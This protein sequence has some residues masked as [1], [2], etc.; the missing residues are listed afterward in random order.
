MPELSHDAQAIVDAVL[1]LTRVTM[2]TSG[3]FK[4]KT[5][6]MRILG[7][8]EIPPVRIAAIL[9]TPP[10]NVRSALAKARK[11]AMKSSQVADSTTPT[12]E[13]PGGAS[14]GPRT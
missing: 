9:A 8:L 2:A 7:D 14:D 1:D 4:S 5:E 13:K 6:A 12:Q 10:E 3:A 11:K